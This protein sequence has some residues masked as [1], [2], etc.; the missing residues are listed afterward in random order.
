MIIITQIHV[1]P[2]QQARDT[3]GVDQ[4]RDTLLANDA[5]LSEKRDTFSSSSEIS[6]S[7]SLLDE[8]KYPALPPDTE[9]QQRDRGTKR[10]T[11]T[12]PQSPILTPTQPQ[13]PDERLEERSA[14]RVRRADPTS[15]S[16]QAEGPASTAVA[17]DTSSTIS[18]ATIP[19]TPAHEHSPP[20]EVASARVTA[21]A[22]QLPTAEQRLGF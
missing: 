17:D 9:P 5:T 15:E 3:A 21:L 14:K 13:Q 7:F 1:T 20:T 4:N 22:P 10:R 2:A 11:D 16:K 12:A 18:D 6:L 19:L 8:F